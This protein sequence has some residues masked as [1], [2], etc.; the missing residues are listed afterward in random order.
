MDES[1]LSGRDGRMKQRDNTTFQS[2]K[3][4]PPNKNR[5]EQARILNPEGCAV[6]TLFSCVKPTVSISPDKPIP[7]PGQ[8]DQPRTASASETL[9]K[10][11]QKKV[12]LAT[13]TSRTVRQHVL[14]GPRTNPIP[15]QHAKD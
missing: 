8:P 7:H 2:R 6:F 12:V 15:N 5:P 13:Q 1:K 11:S 4:K 9:P 14:T 10:K 3:D